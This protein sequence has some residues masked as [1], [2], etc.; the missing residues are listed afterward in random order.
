MRIL[1]AFTLAI[2]SI[3]AYADTS[4]SDNFE[5]ALD[6]SAVDNNVVEITDPIDM[7][8]L[9]YLI[10][11]SL[12][13]TKKNAR[14]YRPVMI[15]SWSPAYPGMLSSLAAT[16]NKLV[17]IEAYYKKGIDSCSYF[18]TFSTG[19][20]MG[21]TFDKDVVNYAMSDLEDP[22]N[23]DTRTQSSDLIYRFCQK[24]KAN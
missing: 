8:K 11:S 6:R 1:L 22:A 12:Q 16:G 18:Y 21:K 7:A 19:G 24:A 3:A 20:I 23:Y 17:K 13:N 2:F 4:L 10:T 15:T 14:K 5:K 9:S